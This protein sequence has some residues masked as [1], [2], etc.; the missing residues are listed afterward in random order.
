MI[1]HT[2]TAAA[3]DLVAVLPLQIPNPDP[4]QPPG[5]QG[6]LSI[7]GWAKWVALAVTILGLIAAGA[8]MS[9]NS[10]RGEGGEHVGRVGMALVGVIIIAAATS[11]VGFLA[12]A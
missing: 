11:L 5:T 4:I 10:R 9:F 8:M 6:F 3:T 1:L 2:L 12:T 7:M